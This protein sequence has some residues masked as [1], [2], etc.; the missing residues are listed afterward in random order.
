MESDQSSPNAADDAPPPDNPYA[1]PHS[2]SAFAAG[3][4]KQR[5]FDSPS[6]LRSAMRLAKT[7]VVV[8]FT[9]LLIATWLAGSNSAAAAF[10]TVGFLLSFA[11]YGLL[12]FWAFRRGKELQDARE[13]DQDLNY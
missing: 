10:C 3:Q 5:F 2:S 1:S 6:R 4:A 7:V 11:A 9:L 12:Q 13:I 8:F